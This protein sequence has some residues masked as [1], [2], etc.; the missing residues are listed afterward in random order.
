MTST[1]RNTWQRAAVRDF[2]ASTEDFKTAQQVH[3]ELR[4]VGDKIGL[5][6]VYRAL[7]QMA[8]AD[9]VDMVRTPDGEAAYRA[10]TPGH[11]HHLVCRSCAYTVEIEAESVEQ[12][13]REVAAAHGFT[14]AGHEVELFGLCRNCSA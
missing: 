12:W 4:A 11:H 7:Q 13:A 6:T 5:A 2:L 3:A 9:E 10:C 8:D 1:K 14:N